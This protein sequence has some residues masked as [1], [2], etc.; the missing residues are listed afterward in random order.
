ML[1]TLKDAHDSQWTRI[2]HLL[3]SILDA[4]TATSYNALVGPHLDPKKLKRLRPPKP[5]PRPGEEAT[6]KK[7]KATSAELRQ[8]LD[9]F[10]R[11]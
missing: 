1:A 8:V 10:L 7:R 2:E 5:I 11:R 6:R 4:C 9:P 3:A